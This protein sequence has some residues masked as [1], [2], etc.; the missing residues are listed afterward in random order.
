MKREKLF[1]DYID[2]L[3]HWIFFFGF[4]KFLSVLHI[5]I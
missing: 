3:S 4:K 2:A 5:L 1:I